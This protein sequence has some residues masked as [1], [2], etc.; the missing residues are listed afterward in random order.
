MPKEKYL[1]QVV[2][3]DDESGMAIVCKRSDGSNATPAEAAELIREMA[4][5][6]VSSDH[7]SELAE[8]A[9]PLR[10]MAD[11]VEAGQVPMIDA[12][13]PG[14]ERLGGSRGGDA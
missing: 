14:A 6:A 10:E 9:A 8:Q 11:A 3:N 7:A 1:F 13:P 2:A 5:H 4:R 12:L